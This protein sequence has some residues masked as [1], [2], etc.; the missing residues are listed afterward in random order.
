V[1][2]LTA[3]LITAG[4]VGFLRTDAVLAVVIVS[5]AGD[6]SPLAANIYETQLR[7]I[8]G[9]QKPS[10]LSYN[11]I[12]PFNMPTAT[13]AYDDFTDVTKNTYLVTHLNGV[14]DEICTG[15]W[16]QT[17]ET[18]GKTA[19]GF[20]TQFYLTGEPDLS[21][22]HDITVRINGHVVGQVDPITQAP[23]WS[24]DPL[25][26]AIVFEPLFVPEPGKPLTVTYDVACN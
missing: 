6:Q 16:A 19:F 10:L 20:R 18:I 2:A 5:D 12:G 21:N 3:P 9:A 24:Y 22:G 8:K 17:L 26:N 14:K 15:D 1:K 7:N 25:T 4:N 13:C 23:V 11:D